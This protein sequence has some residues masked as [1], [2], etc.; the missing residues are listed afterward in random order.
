[1][2]GYP[3]GEFKPADQIPRVQVL[4]SL[5]SGMGLNGGDPAKLKDAFKDATDIPKYAL[6]A[7]ATA[8][9]HKLVVNHPDP[10]Q[11][12]PNRP[13]TRAEVAAMLYQLLVQQGLIK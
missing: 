1:M 4:V 9:Q 6:G 2:S 11:L 8:N 3:T 5:V 10:Q 12:A 13:A 7:I